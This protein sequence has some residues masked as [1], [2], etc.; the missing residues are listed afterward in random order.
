MCSP[1]PFYKYISAEHFYV[2][3]NSYHI[4]KDLQN[5]I[6]LQTLLYVWHLYRFYFLQIFFLQALIGNQPQPSQISAS[7]SSVIFASISR[8]SS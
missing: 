4:K 2:T 8:I 6:I 1:D 7:I 3:G 5:T